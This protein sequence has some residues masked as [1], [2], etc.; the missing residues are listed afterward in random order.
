MTRAGNS[1][2]DANTCDDWMGAY[3]I[4]ADGV[5]PFHAACQQEDT[6][7]LD[8]LVTY[9]LSQSTLKVELRRPSTFSLI[10]IQYT[11]YEYFCN[12]MI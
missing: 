5:T 4:D 12:V 1:Y 2:V 7:G 9:G 8:W 11:K 10:L 6:T 3:C